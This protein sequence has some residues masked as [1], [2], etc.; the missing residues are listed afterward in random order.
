MIVL[1]IDPGFGVSGFGIVENSRHTIKLLDYGVLTMSSKVELHER[2][3]LFHDFFTQKIIS[4]NITHI[5]LETPFLGKNAQNFLKLGYLRGIIYLLAA[6]NKLGLHEFSPRQIKLAL[7]GYGG[8][9]KVQVAR[10][11]L[12]LFPSIVMGKDLDMT[13]GI[14]IA[15]SG[16]WRSK[17]IGV[18]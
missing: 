7:T 18:V 5:S 8:A 9:E 16:A 17:L 3:L 4:Y 12:A 10:V 14:A 2:V 1:G 15:L 6:Q 13:D 11:I